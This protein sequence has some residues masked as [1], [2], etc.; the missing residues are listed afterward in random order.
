MALPLAYVSL[1]LG[2][3]PESVFWCANITM[4]ASEIVS[5]FVLRKYIRYSIKDYLLKVHARCF[6]VGICSL[7]LPLFISNR[8]SEGF[9]RL[10]VTCIISVISVS[11]FSFFM[12][13]NRKM[14][15]KIINVIRMKISIK[16]WC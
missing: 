14:R 13:M 1:K 2:Y 5:C 9:I 12:G 3:S 4:A 11:F 10:I 7:L 16:E 6:F 8:M 15:T